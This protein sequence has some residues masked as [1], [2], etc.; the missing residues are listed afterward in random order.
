MNTN[1]LLKEMGVPTSPRP[2]PPSEGG[3]GDTL[4][5]YLDSQ[6]QLQF[7]RAETCLARKATL[8]A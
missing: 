5:T 1:D 2:S 7:V 4:N 8:T 3:E 6:Q